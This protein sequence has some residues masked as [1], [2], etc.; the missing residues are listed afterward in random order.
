MPITVPIT[1]N[2]MVRAS[3]AGGS[4]CG[5][6]PVMLVVLGS[7]VDRELDGAVVKYV[8]LSGRMC[9]DN[10]RARVVGWIAGE[11]VLVTYSSPSGVEGE[12]REAEVLFFTATILNR[13]SAKG[14]ERIRPW[15]FHLYNVQR[16][17]ASQFRTRSLGWSPTSSLRLLLQSKRGGGILEDQ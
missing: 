11:A 4:E 7:A 14:M 15:K 2:V 6:A 12:R 5:S 16:E 3:V 10:V 13:L 9:D 1:P 17:K 8:V